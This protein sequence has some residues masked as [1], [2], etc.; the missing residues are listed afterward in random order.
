VLVLSRS[1]DCRALSLAPPRHPHYYLP[2]S[3]GEVEERGS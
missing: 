2:S 3:A 1:R